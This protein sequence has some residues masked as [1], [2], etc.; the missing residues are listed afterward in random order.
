M[1]RQ[2]QQGGAEQDQR[3]LCGDR[4]LIGVFGVLGEFGVLGV[5][6]LFGVAGEEAP[7]GVRGLFGLTVVVAGSNEGSAPGVAVAA[8]TTPASAVG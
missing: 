2:G 6:A 8:T 5:F 4:G 3:A 1:A 7:L